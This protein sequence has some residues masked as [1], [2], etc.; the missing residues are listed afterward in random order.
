[1]NYKKILKESESELIDIGFALGTT[2]EYTIKEYAKEDGIDL[3]W[4][5]I[6]DGVGEWESNYKKILSD[7]VT[8]ASAEGHDSSDDLVGS[9]SATKDQLLGILERADEVDE[10]D[11]RAYFMEGT[12]SMNDYDNDLPSPVEGL[13]FIAPEETQ[14]AIIGNNKLAKELANT[15]YKYLD[16]N[17]VIG[18]NDQAFQVGRIVTIYLLAGHQ[19]VSNKMIKQ[20]EDFGHVMY[21]RED[22]QDIIDFVKDF[23][24]KKGLEFNK[25]RSGMTIK[26]AKRIVKRA[27]YKLQ[28]GPGAGVDITLVAPSFGKRDGDNLPVIASNVIMANYYDSAEYNENYGVDSDI[29]VGYLDVYGIEQETIFE[30]NELDR[31]GN[32]TFM[33]GGG[34]TRAANLPN[35]EVDIL[36]RPEDS[37]NYDD[38]QS[39][40]IELIWTDEYVGYVWGD[41]WNPEEDDEDDEEIRSEI[42]GETWEDFD[43]DQLEILPFLVGFLYKNR[44]FLKISS[45][46]EMF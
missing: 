11:R 15:L 2:D 32:Y 19:I 1:M 46:L 24:E 16:E 18:D 13:D 44:F 10:T 39:A 27:G 28:E 22:Y 23:F 30:F 43:E 41:L 40:K 12:G 9:A 14:K 5:E 35:G 38:E 29:V 4:D 33:V 3:D 42:T 25:W 36:Y 7:F 37:D 45:I 31:E 26:E 34:Y 6:N 21:E 17:Y 20:I 8:S